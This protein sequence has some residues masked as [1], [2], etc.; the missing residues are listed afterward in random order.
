[1]TPHEKRELRAKIIDFGLL[2]LVV[3]FVLSALLLAPNL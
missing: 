3:V 2:C 1:M